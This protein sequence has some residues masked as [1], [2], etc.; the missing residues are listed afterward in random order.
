M[1][2][3]SAQDD[4]DHVQETRRQKVIHNTYGDGIDWRRGPKLGE[5]GAASVFLATL[6]NRT[7]SRFPCAM[8]VKSAEISVSGSLKKERE[9]L[10]WLNG[11]PN[12][13]KCFGEEITCGHDGKKVYNLLLEYGSGGNLLDWINKS[14]GLPEYEARIFT[15]SI[16]EGLNWVHETSFV[17]CDL[18]PENIILVSKSKNGKEFVA[19]ICDFGLAKRPR[20]KLEPSCRGTPKYLSPE[21]VTDGVHERPG[22]I[23]ALG[24]IVLEMLTGKHAW[25][26]EDEGVNYENILKKIGEDGAVPTI[27]KDLSQDAKSFLKCCL[28]REVENRS[29]AEKLLFHPFVNGLDDG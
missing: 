14:A 8:A 1:E 4:G 24:C 2:V 22:D 6:K 25:D 11:C 23:W 20:A 7:H 27:P 21:A 29:A 9:V 16:L 10:G 17:H 18:K 3:Y 5:G 26:V 19:K 13:I 12:I 15:K 28:E